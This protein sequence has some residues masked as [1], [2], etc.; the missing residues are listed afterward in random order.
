MHHGMHPVIVTRSG[1]SIDLRDSEYPA[2]TLEDIFWGLAHR[3]RYSCQTDPTFNL[4]HHCLFVKKALDVIYKDSTL[5]LAGL[6][7]DAG[8][9]ILWDVPAPVK[10]YVYFENTPWEE[11]EHKI[12]YALFQSLGI[13]NHLLTDASLVEIDMLSRVLESERIPTSSIYYKTPKPRQNALIEE[14]GLR[15]LFQETY[16]IRENPIDTFEKLKSS[17]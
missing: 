13:P 15:D 5:S 8:E 1:V 11:V 7:H 12:T 4:G 16:L 10:P 14:Y 3:Y 2:P 17:I 9:A 6:L